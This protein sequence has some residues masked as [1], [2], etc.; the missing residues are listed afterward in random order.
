MIECRVCISCSDGIANSPQARSCDAPDWRRLRDEGLLG[1]IA[2]KLRFIQLCSILTHRKTISANWDDVVVLSAES[3][4]FLSARTSRIKSPC[5]GERRLYSRVLRDSV[6]GI[7]S[8]RLVCT[9]NPADQSVTWNH[10]HPKYL[11]TLRL[12]VTIVARDAFCAEA[13]S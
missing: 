5:S 13:W 2:T 9:F 10:P 7:S 1:S 3:L 6:S 11:L 8:L 4:P 12:L